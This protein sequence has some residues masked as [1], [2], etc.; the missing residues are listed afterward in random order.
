M[1]S[2]KPYGCVFCPT[3]LLAFLVV[4]FF[5]AGARFFAFARGFLSPFAS[6]FAAAG[7]SVGDG[8]T[9]ASAPATRISTWLV[10]FRIGVP[11]ALAPPVNPLSLFPSL[12]PGHAARRPA[13]PNPPLLAWAPRLRFATPAFSA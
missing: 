12:A 10:R 5:L 7:F 11:R 8:L 2:R 4:F 9:R 6:A 3:Y 1:P 13:G